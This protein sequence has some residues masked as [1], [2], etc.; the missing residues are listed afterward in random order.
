LR[1]DPL[2]GIRPSTKPTVR[3]YLG[4]EAGQFR[5]ERIFLWSIERARDPARAYEIYLMKDMPGFARGFWL[6]GFT[7]YR[8]AIPSLAGGAGRGSY[9]NGDQN[10]FGGTPAP[11]RSLT[12]PPRL[13]PLRGDR[14]YAR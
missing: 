1:L 5:A 4:T 2:P 6:T 11:F 3:I 10:Y 8:F 13:L 9:K 14:H 7:N 12:G